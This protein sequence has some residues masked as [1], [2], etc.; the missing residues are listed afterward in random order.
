M[1][2]VHQWTYFWNVLIF[3]IL[4]LYRQRLATIKSLTLATCIQK[5][6]L[7]FVYW[8]QHLKK[9]K[10][11]IFWWDIFWPSSL[12]LLLSIVHLVPCYQS[13]LIVVWHHVFITF[14][15]LKLLNCR[16]SEDQKGFISL[17]WRTKILVESHVYIY[18]M[19]DMLLV[20]SILI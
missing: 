20:S 13:T 5:I 19:R 14:I 12:Q 11:V 7:Y 10:E 16:P 17:S 4:I 8:M 1:Q 6:L 15:H 18:I 2:L 3:S 9:S